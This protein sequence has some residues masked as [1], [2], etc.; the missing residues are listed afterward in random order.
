MPEYQPTPHH[1]ELIGRK[2]HLP[3]IPGNDVRSGTCGK[4]LRAEIEADCVRHSTNPTPDT[5]AGIEQPRAG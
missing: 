5:A 3:H 1:I 2:T 4:H